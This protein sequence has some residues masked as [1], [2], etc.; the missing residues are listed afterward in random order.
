LVS[1]GGR[2]WDHASDSPCRSRADTLRNNPVI[3]RLNARCTF[4]GSS[5]GEKLA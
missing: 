1:R 4:P 5:F 2:T 3:E